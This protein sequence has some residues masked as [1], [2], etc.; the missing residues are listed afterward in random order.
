M[1]LD[2]CEIAEAQSK[3]PG[4]LNKQF[5]DNVGSPGYNVALQNCFLA[6]KL[7]IQT[8]MRF[9]A[10]YNIFDRYGLKLTKCY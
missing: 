6:Q 8:S 5:D 4:L 3:K 1:T 2:T 9:K 7:Q 10:I